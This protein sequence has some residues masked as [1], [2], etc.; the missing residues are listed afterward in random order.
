MAG[1]VYFLGTGG[2]N[3]ELPQFVVDE[4][5][6][7]E[8][9]AGIIMGSVAVTALLTRAYFGRMSDRRGA[10]SI[11]VVGSALGVVS[12]AVLI[13]MPT[14]SGAFMS[15]LI[16]GAGGA[17]FMTGATVLAIELAPIDRRSQAASFVLVSFHA[18]MGFGPMLMGWVSESA[19]YRA[20][21]LTVLA[22]T[23]AAGVVSFLL[24][25]RPGEP[26]AKPTPLVHRAALGPGTVTLLGVIAFNGFMMFLPLYARELD[27]SHGLLFLVS[28][29]TI[30]FIRVFFGRV[31]DVVGPVRAGSGALVTTI[32]AASVIAWWATPFG[33]L[34]GTVLVASGLSML[35]PSFM[36]MA[37][38]G[39]PDGERGSVMATYSAFYDIAGA[40]IGPVFGVTIGRFGYPA[41]FSLAGVCAVAALVVLIFTV[42][43]NWT[44]RVDALASA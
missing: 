40:V 18:G 11:M 35:S 23:A 7:T 5:D 12:L 21:F 16:V 41:A 31:P 10:R 22:L 42:A 27:T 25:H 29:I 39:A 43:P 13:A 1:A 4:L 3:A 8:A 20:M 24:E 2:L 14:V 28:S 9:T 17:A 37:A 30:V 38:D 34:V 19:S 15:R 44:R 32:V 36:K 33:L 6:G 26:D